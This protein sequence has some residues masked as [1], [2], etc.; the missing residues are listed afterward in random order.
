MEIDLAD[1]AFWRRPLK[2]RYEAFARLR[3]L[4]LPVFFEEKRVPLL[5]SGGGSTP[6]SG[7]PTWWRPAATPGCSPASPV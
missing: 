6:W 5:R 7:T 2:E 3:D 4:D 1:L